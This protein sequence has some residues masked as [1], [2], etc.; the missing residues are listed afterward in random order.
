MK[1]QW[2]GGLVVLSAVASAAAFAAGSGSGGTSVYINGAK[3]SSQVRMINGT[4]YVPLVDIAKAYGSQV[5]KRPDGDY[6]IG[7]AGGAYEVGKHRGKLGQEVF[8]GQFRFS[9]TRVEETASYT[10]KYKTRQDTL[11]T[12][13]PGNKL[14]V[15][16]CRIKN[17]VPA[18]QSLIMTV[19]GNYGSPDTALTT[20]DEQSFPPINWHGDSGTGGVDVHE[21]LH[22]PTGIDLLPGAAR[23]VNLVFLVPKNTKPKDLIFCLTR[24]DEWTKGD[25][26]KFTDVRVSLNP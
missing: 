4:A 1:K 16:S 7:P 9:V 12:D 20:T 3:A 14:V 8:T 5:G 15:V 2:F 23:N 22:A 6:E 21:D 18:K 11:T 17:G 10:T 13:N 19:G 26:K 24:Y 25:K